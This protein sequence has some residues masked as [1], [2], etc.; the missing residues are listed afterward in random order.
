MADR[1]TDA[2]IDILKRCVTCEDSY[3]RSYGDKLPDEYGEVFA[4]MRSA[5]ALENRGLVTVRE[6][7][8]TGLIVINGRRRAGPLKRT[9]CIVRLT[10]AGRE[11]AETGNFKDSKPMKLSAPMRDM[12]LDCYRYELAMGQGCDGMKANANV[13]LALWSRNLVAMKSYWVGG[14]RT[15]KPS[16]G[17]PFKYW[18]N[19]HTNITVIRLTES[20]KSLVEGILGYE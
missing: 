20:G 7:H 3:R 4:D 12:L 11:A 8:P 13:A 16:F 9:V 15:A 5:R 1:L 14:M 18:D 17:K 2:Q 19:E 10:P 6:F